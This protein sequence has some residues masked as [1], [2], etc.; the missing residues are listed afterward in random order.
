M[1]ALLPLHPGV[2]E[3]PLAPVTR[4]LAAMR[5]RHGSSI[6]SGLYPGLVVTDPT[7]WTPATW[8]TDG[9]RVPEL[10]R[11]AERRWNAQP[12]AAAALAWKSYTYWVA[13]PAVLGYAAARRVPLVSADQV[14]VRFHD[15]QPF[16]TVALRA[17]V[18]TAVLP[19]DPLAVGPVPG[20]RVVPDAET[21]LDALRVAVLDEHLT[22]LLAQLRA[23]VHI[24][25][26]T[27]LGSIASG[28]SYAV[29]RAAHVLPDRPLSVA[30]TLLT[31][32][33]VAGLVDV[34]EDDAGG[35]TIRRRT[36]C[37]AFTLPEP[38]ICAGCCLR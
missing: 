12:H 32:L 8:L 28:V 29:A 18:A 4:S 38:K 10:L 33:D 9:S 2:A 19:S 25:S 31:A 6:T 1:T 37:L 30:R 27:L 14:L 34:G 21:L 5:A 24:G 22:P 17:G 26:R 35:L 3:L 13:L 7:G 36:C 16:L 20:V 15:Q 11:T 23:D